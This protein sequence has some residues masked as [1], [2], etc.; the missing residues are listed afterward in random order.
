MLFGAFN[1]LKLGDEVY[2]S[3]VYADRCLPDALLRNEVLY[4]QCLPG[5]L[6][7]NDFLNFAKVV[8]FTDQCLFM[9]RPITIENLVLE[10][11]VA[12]LKFTSATY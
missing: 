6:Y 8:G 3:D 12:L 1:L 5:T 9:H 11:A 2:F 7:W 4:R 10:A